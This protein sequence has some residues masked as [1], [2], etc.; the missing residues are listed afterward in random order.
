[1]YS[2]ISPRAPQIVALTIKKSKEIPIPVD[3]D[4]FAC[5]QSSNGLNT[6]ATT[7]SEVTQNES[8]SQGL[9]SAINNLAEQLE[10]VK[11]QV[12][13]V[14]AENSAIKA[15]LSLA[16]N[17]SFDTR[18]LQDVTI[19]RLKADNASLRERTMSLESKIDT[20]IMVQK[21]QGELLATGA[22]TSGSWRSSWAAVTNQT[23]LLLPPR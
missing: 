14:G 11:Q 5:G 10:A 1:M 13:H 17:R 18:T 12:H 8:T 19:D 9:Q 20:F 23:N 21:V 6:P 2:P 4:E 3:E 15:S 16:T 22:A 7:V